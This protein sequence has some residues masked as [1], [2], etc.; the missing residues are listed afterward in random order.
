MG[1][2]RPLQALEGS[3]QRATHALEII[4]DEKQVSARAA[5]NSP[6]TASAVETAAT[7]DEHEEDDDQKS[8][9]IHGSLLAETKLSNLVGLQTSA[10]SMLKWSGHARRAW[11][12]TPNSNQRRGFPHGAC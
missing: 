6:P 3:D 9:A 2:S 1:K 10:P 11:P 7:K 4:K 8:S 12:Y 5:G